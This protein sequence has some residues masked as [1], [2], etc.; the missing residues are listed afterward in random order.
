MRGSHVPR[1]CTEVYLEVKEA[2]EVHP[3]AG[4]AGEEHLYTPVITTANPPTLLLLT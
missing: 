4:E 1:G 3:E 2:S